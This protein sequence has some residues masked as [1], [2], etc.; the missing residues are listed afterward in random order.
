M[1]IYSWNAVICNQEYR[2]QLYLNIFSI[3]LSAGNVT[4]LE[5]VA[6]RG[7]L[8]EII[9]DVEPPILSNLELCEELYAS[10]NIIFGDCYHT[11][12]KTTS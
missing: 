2:R 11:S 1:Y 10:Q 9:S 8:V 12:L 4:F 5:T 3:F 6:Q 7:K